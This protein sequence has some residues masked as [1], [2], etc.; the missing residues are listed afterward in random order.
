MAIDKAVDSTVL[1]GYFDDIADAI[2]A[3]DGSQ[4]TYTPAQMPTAIANIPSGGG[5]TFGDILLNPT[6]TSY[7][8]NTVTSIPA[9]AFCQ[10][11]S[12]QSLSFANVQYINDNAFQQ[13]NALRSISFPQ[14]KTLGGYVFWS[15]GIQELTIPNTFLNGANNT[16]YGATQLQKIKFEGHVSNIFRGFFQSCSNCLEYDFTHCTSVPT[17][18]N[19]N[20]FNGINANA[21]IVVPD[22]L[23]STW[24]AASNWVT[25]ASYIIKESDYNAS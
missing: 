20:A 17:L 16:F 4:T 23:Y 14:L 5:D 21:K 7:T 13:A 10:A 12:I 25:Y 11:I 9:Y 6:Q 18:A 24:I 3:K 15:S 2:R 22:D 19:A 1:D 8:N